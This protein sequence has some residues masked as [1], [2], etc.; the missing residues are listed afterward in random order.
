[1][2]LSPRGPVGDLFDRID[3]SV[4]ES[5]VELEMDRV[6]VQGVALHAMN[7]AGQCDGLGFAFDLQAETNAHI[8]ADSWIG[9]RKK[10]RLWIYPK[11]RR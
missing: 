11:V 7:N 3:C 6:F 9:N 5:A 1:M 4:T 2:T 10:A 8:P